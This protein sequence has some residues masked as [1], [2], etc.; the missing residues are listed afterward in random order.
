M[1]PSPPLR[2]VSTFVLL[3]LGLSLPFWIAGARTNVVLAPGLPVSALMAVCPCAAAIAITG[4]RHQSSVRDL[5]RQP[6]DY[7]KVRSSGWLLLA[8]TLKPTIMGLSYVWIRAIGMQ[9]PSP[10]YGIAAVIAVCAVFFAAAVAEETGWTAFATHALVRAYSPLP[11]A[12]TIGSVWAAWHLVPLWQADR[13]AAWIAWHAAETIASRVLIVWLYAWNDRC[14]ALA[15]LYHTADNASWLLFPQ[16]GS[17]YT[18]GATAPLTMVA[19]AIAFVAWPAVASPP[20]TRAH[21]CTSGRDHQCTTH[22][23]SG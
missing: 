21:P 4:W 20:A 3:L 1:R 5:V 2:L 6:F 10:H 11:V 19:A 7:A 13:S 15:V 22:T 9:V 8:L 16:W 23:K 17:L 14:V 12:V 18:P